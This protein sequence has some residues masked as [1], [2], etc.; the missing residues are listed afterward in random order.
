MTWVPPS[1]ASQA[2]PSWKALAGVPR[3]AVRDAG[4]VRGTVPLRSRCAQPIEVFNLH[5]G[6]AKSDTFAN[7]AALVH[8]DLYQRPAALLKLS[9]KDVHRPASGRVASP[10]HAETSFSQT[11]TQVDTTVVGMTT[12]QHLWLGGLYAEEEEVVLVSE[13][14]MDPD[15]AALH[16]SGGREGPQALRPRADCD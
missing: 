2:Q 4:C 10:L 3:L 12:A 6:F 11:M 5:P 1:R 7:A 15:R 13:Y 16:Q 8:F 14:L 9:C